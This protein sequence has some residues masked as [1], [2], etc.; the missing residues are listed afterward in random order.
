MRLLI[1]Q[2]TF[3]LSEQLLTCNCL[4]D[5]R[6]WHFPRFFHVDFWGQSFHHCQFWDSPKCNIK[7]KRKHHRDQYITISSVPRFFKSS[8][9]GEN[10][11]NKPV[12]GAIFFL[13]QCIFIVNNN[14]QKKEWKKK[15]KM[16][17]TERTKGLG[18]NKQNKQNT[19]TN[20][21]LPKDKIWFKCQ[22]S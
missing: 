19:N 14:I 2:Q 11:V 15:G 21:T 8:S 16:S 6:G 13:M 9:E 22:V 3:C 12:H 7:E 10:A 1:P 4:G 17:F 5:L 18:G 20:Q